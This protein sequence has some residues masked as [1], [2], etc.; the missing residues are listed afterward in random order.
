M[1]KH[2][3]LRIIQGEGMPTHRHPDQRG[4]LIIQFSVDFPAQLTTKQ[5]DQLRK[6]LPDDD[7]VAEEPLIPDGAEQISLVPI[8]DEMLRAQAREEE[9]RNGG[10]QAVRC[11]TQ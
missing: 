7:A 10:P 8:S 2:H 9:M 3:D 1:I 4:D 11:A 5:V 6:L